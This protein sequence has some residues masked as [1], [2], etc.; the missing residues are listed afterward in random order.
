MNEYQTLK[1][2]FTEGDDPC[3]KVHANP[4]GTIV[5]RRRSDDVIVAFG[6]VRWFLTGIKDGNHVYEKELRGEPKKPKTLPAGT[7]IDLGGCQWMVFRLE[8]GYWTMITSDGE[9]Y[10][11]AA[12]DPECNGCTSYV[13]S[14]LIPKGRWPTVNILGPC[15]GFKTKGEDL[16]TAEW[17][18]VREVPE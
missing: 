17:R 1:Q 7:V 18:G 2:Y 15:T 12:K 8:T 5:I 14:F 9:Q 16:T 11:R 6:P 13:V 10:F 4:D 3:Y